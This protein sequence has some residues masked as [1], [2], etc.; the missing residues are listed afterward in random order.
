MKKW[1]LCAV[2]AIAVG[3]AWISY[4]SKGSKIDGVA[5]EII[6]L[7]DGIREA[8]DP[9]ARIKELTK[10]QKSLESERVFS[11][12]LLTF[13]SAGLIGIVLVSYVI[14]MMAEKVSHSVY[15]SAEMM[16]KDGMHDARSLV[17]QGDY[18]GAIDAFKEAAKK[19]PLNRLPWV[20]IAKI[21][22]DDLDDP[23]AA[24]ATIRY[25][26]E[27]QEWQV[28]DAAYFLFRLAELFDEV[29]GDRAA[30]IEVMNQVIR[31]YPD[32]RHS[33]NANHK[34]HEWSTGVV[35]RAS[36]QASQ[37]GDAERLAREEAEFLAKMK[38][39]DS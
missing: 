23:D 24:V 26:L 34:L 8:D 2:F 33:A 12:I 15:D 37:A 31:D 5:K 11:G 14:P 6:E 19:D 3:G 1:I 28:N 30:A 35:Q 17:A 20:E 7:K 9:D 25:A 13:V 16:E 22:K 39:G 21:Q 36:G 38:G 27:S 32:T 29:K 10:E 18:A 4:L